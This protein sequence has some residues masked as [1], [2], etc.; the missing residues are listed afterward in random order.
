MKAGW[1]RI[2]FLMLRIGFGLLLITASIGKIVDP[3]EFS[4]AV[5]N[6]RVF[7]TLLSRW[8]AVFMPAF[9]LLTGLCLIFGI[10]QDAAILVNATLMTAFL[11]LVLQ[12]Y[13]RNLN[14]QCGCFWTGETK[15]DVLKIAENLFFC[16]GSAVLYTL[17]RLRRQSPTNS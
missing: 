17:Y 16:A 7:G 13:F 5:D 4:E 15:I 12:A 10:W 6:Y 2:P 11:A 3:L 8:A 9:E 14:I 1:R